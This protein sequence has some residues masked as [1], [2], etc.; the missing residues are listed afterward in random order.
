LSSHG[1]LRYLAAACL[2]VAVVAFSNVSALA[3]PE[4]PLLV[5]GGFETGNTTGWTA[6]T[7]TLSVAS[8]AFQG[9][10]A[11]KASYT[12]SA[13][14]G[15]RTSTKPVVGGT[16]GAQYTVTGMVRSETPGRQVCIF[17]TEYS[18]SGAQ[19]RQT[20]S[21]AKTQTVWS[22]LATSTTALTVDGGSLQLAV[23]E[24]SAISGDSFE[25]DNLNL[26]RE[27]TTPTA[28]AKWSMNEPTGPTMFDSGAAP[29]N[30]GTLTNVT[31]G[32]PG[33][34]GTTGYGFTRGSISVPDDASLDP[35]TGN[36]TISMS[37][38]PSSL[39]T[40]GDFD[41][42]RKGDSPG[43]QMK[44]EILQ[45]GALDCAFRGT[46]GAKEVQSTVQL[47][48][49]TGYHSLQC[50]KTAN[51]VKAVVDGTV[52]AVT[53]NIG[54]I[55]NNANVVIGAHGTGTYDFYKGSLDDVRMT[56]G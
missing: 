47:V 49:N 37:A 19:I 45:S 32:V 1:S 11:G 38:N 33:V 24:K 40:S 48:P 46:S 29:S 15:L 23:R 30:N 9:S 4:S 35:D 16:M 13:S 3:G 2:A 43:L 25:V 36:V 18:S 26:Y 5:N 44:V 42:I 52:T 6:V 21:C 51:Q 55:F 22:P 56:F 41:V 34:N 27:S 50:I 14:F 12:N 7:S 28:V 54:A 31:P 39:A 53:A 17:L 8:D 10:W 20:S